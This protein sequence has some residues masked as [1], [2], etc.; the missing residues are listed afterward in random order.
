MSTSPR[1]IPS[2]RRFPLVVYTLVV[3]YAAIALT[4]YSFDLQTRMAE[5]RRETTESAAIH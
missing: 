5:G 2:R 4:L 1:F 3:P